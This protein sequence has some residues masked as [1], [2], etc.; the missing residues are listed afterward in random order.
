MPLLSPEDA[1]LRLLRARRAAFTIEYYREQDLRL[2]T[3]EKDGRRTCHRRRMLQARF[4][5]GLGRLDTEWRL[6][7]P[8]P[9]RIGW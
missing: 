7:S 8:R 2:G 5:A 3:T 4:E 9:G 6:D 1:E